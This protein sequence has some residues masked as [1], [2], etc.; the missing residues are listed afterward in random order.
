M[1]RYARKW[2][3]YHKKMGRKPRGR[4]SE[5][6]VQFNGVAGEQILVPIDKDV[7][8]WLQEQGDI[9]SEVNGL[10][11]FYMDTCITRDLEFDVDEFEAAHAP[12]PLGGPER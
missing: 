9:T 1:R 3:C 10:C 7:A 11:R 6:S 12:K 8:E 5:R 4:A 2:P